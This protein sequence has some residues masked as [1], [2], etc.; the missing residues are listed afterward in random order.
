MRK[1][2]QEEVKHDMSFS[3]LINGS[4]ICDEQ[5]FCINPLTLPD[6][7]VCYISIS[8]LTTISTRLSADMNQSFVAQS[9]VSDFILCML[10]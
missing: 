8:A 4:F 9:R 2:K 10:P 3:M 7:T 6:V 5:H 1:M